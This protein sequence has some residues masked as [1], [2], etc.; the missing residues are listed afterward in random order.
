MFFDGEDIHDVPLDVLRGGVGYVPQD[1]F[2]FSASVR[3]NIR[4]YAPNATDEDVYAAA[5]LADIYD[6]VMDFPDGF[7]TEVGERGVTLSGGQKQRVSIARALVK[8]PRVLIL[9]DAL[10]A[11]DAETERHIW[12]SLQGVLSSGAS[13]IVIAHRV[14][15]LMHCDEILVLDEGRVI[16]RGT[17]EQLLALGGRYA[18]TAHEQAAGEEAKA[19]AD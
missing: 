13:G 14:S 17:H 18:R 12:A 2:L 10:S 3:E 16:E 5:K 15:A 7:D 6:A 9:D 11:V 8:K 4:F 1:N 19:H